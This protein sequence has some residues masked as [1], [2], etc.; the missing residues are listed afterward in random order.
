MIRAIAS[1]AALL[2]GVAILLVGQGLQGTLLP[3]R[4]T[5]ENFTTLAVGTFGATYFLG[6]ALGCWR[7]PRLVQRVGHVRVFAAMTAL[8]SASPLLHGLWINLWSWTLLRFI[9]G[10]CFAALY[11]VIESW[12][13]ETATNEN[14]GSVFSAYVL[15]NMT[16]LA[17]GQQMM[18]LDD[19]AVMTL[20][21][22]ASV[23]VSLAALP[24]VLST[25]PSP[26]EVQDVKLDLRQ[27]YRTSPAGML[28]SLAT[29]LANGSFWS[30]APVF[31]ISYSSDVSLTA[32]FMTAV[33]IGG[34]ASQWPLGA[35]SDRIDRRYVMALCAAFAVAVSIAIWGFAEHMTF[36]VIVLLGGLWGAAAFPL[37]SISVAHANDY[38]APDEFVVVSSGLL[39]MYGIG[40]VIGPLLA[41]GLMYT[42]GTAGLYVFTGLIHVILLVYLFVRRYRRKAAAPGEQIAFS[43]ALTAATTRSQVFEHEV[44]TR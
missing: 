6:F 38:A 43:E 9:S 42:L 19:P 44:E 25:A 2:T 23:L 24:V 12:L 16:M 3:V 41:S 15:I 39:L 22:L 5:M 29:G 33:V 30:L 8:A 1:I 34:A 28:G 18:L 4:A 10:F 27:L 7:G 20:F 40:A 35:L 14:R 32:W 13:N 26:R 36:A 21:A 31:T 17:V 37:Y 11:V